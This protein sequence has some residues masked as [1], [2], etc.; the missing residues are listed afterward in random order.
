MASVTTAGS[1]CKKVEG[2]PGGQGEQLEVG[3][4][5]AERHLMRGL[6]KAASKSAQSR[7]EKERRP[8]TKLQ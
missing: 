8:L 2:A 4:G 1:A 3:G 6:H 7:K 5:G